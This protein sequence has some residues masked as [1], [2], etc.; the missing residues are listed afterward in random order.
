MDGEETI[1]ITRGRS[2]GS[3]K[4]ILKHSKIVRAVHKDC[5]AGSLGVWEPGKIKK[6]CTYAHTLTAT[7]TGSCSRPAMNW[8]LRFVSLMMDLGYKLLMARESASVVCVDK[9]KVT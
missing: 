2:K 9:V 4:T 8:K 7:S 6:S 1:S 3:I 5:L